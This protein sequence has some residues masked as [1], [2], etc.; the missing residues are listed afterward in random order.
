MA[1]KRRRSIAKR[2]LSQVR[3]VGGA[4]ITRLRTRLTS[5]KATS[6]RARQKAGEQVENI[7]GVALTG[8]SSY[9]FGFGRGAYGPI[10]FFGVPLELGVAVLGHAAAFLGLG[11][12]MAEKSMRHIGTGALATWAAIEGQRMGLEWAEKR[13]TVSGDDGQ[14]GG[15]RGERLSMDE[16]LSLG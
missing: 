16:L 6:T 7:V 3:Q 13:P 14:R 4:E 9:G 10:E 15:T 2:R 12:D 11:G 8:A 1:K 5:L